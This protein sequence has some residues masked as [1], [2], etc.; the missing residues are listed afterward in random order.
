[1][2]TR[3]HMDDY[4]PPARVYWWV[5][6]VLG[7]SILA[8][9]FVQVA[10]LDRAA[11]A[12][13]A[14]GV[15]IAAVIGLY[16][17][18]I[19][20]AKTSLAGAE[21]FIFLLLLLHGPAAATLA[22][23]VEAA[24]A[25]WRTS[26]RWTSRIGSPTMAALAM[27]GCGTVFGIA[28]QQSGLNPGL[29]N[30]A[31]FV[32]L[33]AFA[34]AYFAAGTLLMV[35]LI[36]LKKGEPVDALKQLKD[37]RWIGLAY[38]ASASIAGLVYV[39]FDR[40]GTPVLLAAVPIIAMF[41]TT[42]RSYF[43]QSEVAERV[44]KERVQSAEREAALAARHL[45]E[46]KES[47][48]RFH[49]AFT[50]AAVGMVLVSTECRILQANDALAVLLGRT[51][52]ALVGTEL[53]KLAHPDDADSL[54]AEIG[55]LL[56]GR[57]T[58]CSAELRF[59]HMN[60]HEVWVALNASFFTEGSSTHRCL[61]LQIQ[62]ISA[63]RQAETRL[64]FIAYHDGLT[65]LPNRVHFLEQL[66]RAIAVAKRQPERRFAVLFLDFDRFK[67]IND[68]LGHRIGDEF[69]V[70]IARRL[71]AS[72]RPGD[73][74]ARLGGDEFAILVQDM[75]ST[76][77]LVGL[78]DRLQAVISKPIHLADSDVTA[79]ASIGITTS[80]FGYDLPEQALRD[81]DIAMYR[82][83]VLGKAQH[84]LFDSTMHAQVSTRLWLEN[85][86]RRALQEQELH[87]HYQPIY[88]LRTR[89]LCGIEALARWSHGVNG[90][91]RPGKFIPV[92][93][94][95]GLIIPL[96]NWALD[97]A[98]RQ[99]RVWQS[100]MP[101][102]DRISLHVNVS[103]LQMAQRG[104]ANTVKRTLEAAQIQPA[105][106]TLELTE[107]VLIERL[108]AALPNL[109]E[110]RKAGVHI[111]IDDFGTGY[112]SLSALHELPVDE[113]KV[114]RSFVTRM[115][116]GRSGE[117][118]VRA[119]VGLA[120]ALGKRVVVEGIETCHQL[121]RLVE[122][123]CDR[124]QGFLL[125]YPSPPD[126][127][128]SVLNRDAPYSIRRANGTSTSPHAPLLDAAAAADRPRVAA[129]G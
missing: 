93:E 5:T 11:L 96:G 63:R 124:G 28:L 99:F 19:P 49:S 116:R 38:M 29:R 98:C 50:H 10:G 14:A 1:M 18:R 91:I 80:E 32:G 110:L 17:V 6:M 33:L 61:I 22:A 47:E 53:S 24:I 54:Q 78:A 12:Q 16:P 114:D 126:V 87:L 52:A 121:D 23:A 71:Q 40:F 89:R 26:K 70:T 27:Y 58:T 84:A 56:R 66:S 77:E 125:A 128:E 44:Q 39:S 13:V 21:I 59:Q 120:R 102:R 48:S 75:Q 69:L 31:V 123:R 86:L 35:S 108:P 51:A 97:H 82:A 8:L 83:K 94:E 109:A 127:V 119:V 25:S 60:G 129:R 65:A 112:S 57:V 36:S 85:E 101:S 15:L 30:T 9:S 43:R 90:E 41:L 79:S 67:L 81:A 4:T 106:L 88:N 73:L 37:N 105:Q 113:I 34:L 20:G 45:A 46:M 111:S 64:Q 92:A 95:T 103:G 117:E 115:E 122:L 2:D 68:T 72:V 62:D 3:L 107:N 100:T 74:V 42:I 118:V 104:Y 76:D 55:G 7:A